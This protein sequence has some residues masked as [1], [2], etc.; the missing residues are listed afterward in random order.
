ML[1]NRRPN[2]SEIQN[3]MSKLSFVLKTKQAFHL[4]RDVSTNLC[5]ETTTIRA[6][7]DIH[8][9]I[10]EILLHKFSPCI[11]RDAFSRSLGGLL[12]VSVT[13]KTLI[14]FWE[15]LHTKVYKFPLIVANVGFHYI[16][17]L[18]VLALAKALAK[19]T[20]LMSMKWETLI[21]FGRSSVFKI[22]SVNF[23]AKCNK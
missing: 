13:S 23:T 19:T 2:T 12:N 10:Q 5:E 9:G 16:N 14:F 3:C 6:T 7:W 20:N 15:Y 18:C 8:K 17:C 11:L 21:M 4:Y 22:Y 1:S